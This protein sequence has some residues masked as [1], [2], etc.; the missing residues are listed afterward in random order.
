MIPETAE[1]ADARQQALT[2]VALGVGVR[3]AGE[4]DASRR[5]EVILNAAAGGGECEAA[6]DRL[7]K[8]F[9]E[10]RF[11]ARVTLARGG[12]EILGAARRA[13]GDDGVG[14]VVAGGGD[15][16]INAVAS[17]LVGTEKTLGVL[18]FGTLNHFAKDLS[19]PLDPDEAARVVVAGRT[20][21]VD[22]GEVNGRF[23]LNNSSL[24]LY[25]TLVREREKL[26]ERSGQGKW[27]AAFRAALTV[28]RRYPFLSVRLDADGREL[29]RRTPFVCIGNNEYELDAFHVGT[30]ARLDAGTLSLH[31]TRDI[32]RWGLARLAFRA[33]FGRL[34]ED[35]DFDALTAREVWIETRHSRVRVATD[36]EVRVMRPPLCYRV[37]PQALRVRV[38]EREESERGG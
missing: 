16:T 11:D 9:A 28:L 6:R 20:A 38:P 2:G 14:I 4:R 8:F 36:G 30:R 27:S 13:A 12:E 29:R 15:G 19:I 22:V 23:F 18:P 7:E 26:Q 32:G 24:G 34:R 31:V 33:L 37:L 1:T 3:G 17:Q 35:K 21:L 25:P 10:S 5:A